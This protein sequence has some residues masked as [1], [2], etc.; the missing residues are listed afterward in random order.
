[1]A[2]PERQ[3][4]K[5]VSLALLYVLASPIYALRAIARYF[6]A[7]RARALIE[8]GWV[9]CPYCRHGNKLDVFVR[10]GRCS[11][12]EPRSLAI[13]CSNCGYVPGWLYCAKCG[14]SLRLP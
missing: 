6:A 11:F 2:D 1:M 4:S 9:K 10:C 13:P 8:V 14:S 12:V 3:L 7:R 5:L